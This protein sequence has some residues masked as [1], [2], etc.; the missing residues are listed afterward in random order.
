MAGRFRL[1]AD[2][3]FPTATIKAL[4]QA[5]WEVLRVVD[6]LGQATPDEAVFDHAA[7]KGLVIVTSDERAQKAAWERL[8]EGKRFPGM[9]VWAQRH[10][11]KVGPGGFVRFVEALSEEEAPFAYGIRH[12]RPG[13]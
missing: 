2:E 12:V 6:V 7:D 11:R 8:R 9:I 5:G 13:A 4:A 10:R 1:L 3:H